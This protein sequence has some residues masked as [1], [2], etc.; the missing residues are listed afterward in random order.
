MLEESK[1][2]KKQI[3]SSRSSQFN[4]QGFHLATV[5]C[6]QGGS[7]N[8]HKG[9]G[10]VSKWSFYVFDFT[11]LTMFVK[12][13]SFTF[14]K[15]SQSGRIKKIYKMGSCLGYLCT[16]LTSCA[17]APCV[18]VKVTL[19]ACLLS[20]GRLLNLREPWISGLATYFFLSNC[21]FVY[22]WI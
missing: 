7:A 13:Q 2:I 3:L 1:L 19:Q 15:K 14:F 9:V 10:F 16:K 22:K 4:M 20:W 6:R 5:S 17:Y 11:W 18:T 12:L 21:N 8:K